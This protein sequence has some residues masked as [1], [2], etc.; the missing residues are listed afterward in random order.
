[1]SNRHQVL[2]SIGLSG[3]T[4]D[5]LLALREAYCLLHIAKQTGDLRQKCAARRALELAKRDRSEKDTWN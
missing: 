1:M 5:G 2:A 3:R 4:I